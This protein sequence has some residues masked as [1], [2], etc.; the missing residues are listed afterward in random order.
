MGQGRNRFD[1]ALMCGQ[2]MGVGGAN[3]IRL[4]VWMA[5]IGL[6]E[7]SGDMREKWVWAVGSCQD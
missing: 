7:I 2:L 5:E 6:Q 4:R 1:Y 3:G